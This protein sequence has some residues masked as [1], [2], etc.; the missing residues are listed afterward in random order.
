VLGEPLEGRL[1]I[2]DLV[3]RDE[4]RAVAEPARDPRLPS[5]AEAPFVRRDLRNQ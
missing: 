2:P 3:R 4:E 1:L 5:E